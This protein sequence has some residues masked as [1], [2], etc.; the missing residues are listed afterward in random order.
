MSLITVTTGVGCG[1]RQVTQ[2]V[3]EDLK[4]ELYDDN[5]LQQEAVAL[6][7]SSEDLKAFDEKAPGLFDR[8][9]RRRPEIYDELMA[10]VIYE[11]ARRGEGVL[12]GH[13]SFYFLKDFTCAL[14]LRLHAS[15]P[16]RIQR[17]A[18]TVKLSPDTAL[19]MIEKSDSELK[20]FL[21]FLFQIDWNDLS[22]YD[23][24]VNVD[25][26]GID[27]AAEMI[28]NLAQTEHIQECSLSALDSME[29]LSLLKRVETAVF[30]DNINPQELAIEVPEAGVVKLVGVINPMRTVAGVTELVRSVPGVKKVVCEAERHPMAKM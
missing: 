22:L 16:F 3:A 26:L 8:L 5:R 20:S 13:G 6:G 27:A 24:V 21:D 12:I 17:L 25:K 18:D 14:H 4:L 19:K 10:A 7:Y 29:K 2:K 15:R 30:K 1:A 28:V 23:L 11:V 9:L